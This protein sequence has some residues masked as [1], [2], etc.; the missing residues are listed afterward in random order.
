MRM[1]AW[2]AILGEASVW[3]KEMR[4]HRGTLDRVLAQCFL[5]LSEKTETLREVGQ[6]S[7]QANFKSVYNFASHLF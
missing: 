7:P 6:I 4:N 2:L 1:A 3:M 5:L